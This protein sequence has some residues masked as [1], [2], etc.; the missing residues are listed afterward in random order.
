MWE[1]QDDAGTLYSGS[2]E[3]MRQ[4]FYNS[5]TYSYNND[6]DNFEYIENWNGDLKLVKVIDTFR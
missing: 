3:E 6:E 1:I 4:L 5:K 2:E